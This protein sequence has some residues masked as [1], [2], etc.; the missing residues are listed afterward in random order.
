MR[1]SPMGEHTPTPWEIRHRLNSIGDKM[2]GGRWVIAQTG[3]SKREDFFIAEMPFAA[4][5]SQDE[6]EHDANAAF[7][8]KAVN[9]HALMVA[10]LHRLLALYGNQETAD[11]LASIRTSQAPSP[12]EE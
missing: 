3:T 6:K 1:M 7:I 5:R 2:N 9:N 8:V 10:E 4:C 12:V 11:V